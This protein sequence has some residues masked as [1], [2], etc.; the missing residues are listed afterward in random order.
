MTAA[1]FG[2]TLEQL[3][4]SDKGDHDPERAA[5]A[6]GDILGFF[7]SEA[8]S[9]SDSA[10]SRGIGDQG[11]TTNTTT[12]KTE[13]DA[14][15]VGSTG[16]HASPVP[17]GTGISG[18]YGE[19]RGGRAHGGI[20]FAVPVGTTL[21][22]AASGTITNASNADPGGYGLYVEIT[23][24][25]GFVIRYGHMDATSVQVGDRVRAGQPVGKSGGAG[26]PNSGNSTGAHLHF[27]VQ[28][29]S[30][31]IDPTPFLAG[32]YQIL[33]GVDTGTTTSVTTPDP[34]ALAAVQ[35]QNIVSGLSGG[36]L[37]PTDQTTTTTTTGAQQPSAGSTG[38]FARDLLAGIGAPITEAN[39]RAIEAWVRAEGMDAENN[40]PLAT[41]WQVDGARVLNSHGVKAYSSYAQ[42]L[43]A[44]IKT[45][46]NGL[47]G[48][49]IQALM[50]GSDPMA[51]A[52]AIESSP[53]GT[54]GLVKKIL[55]GG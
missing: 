11:I 50:S 36:A 22:A 10:I 24:D 51:V 8:M 49:I 26:G 33:G 1:D 41:T 53:W 2:S 37:Q 16:D 3:F 35:I 48:N 12:T 20:D 18:A 21:L 14:H 17:E 43:D 4:G 34:Q 32:G 7:H 55:G 13:G 44:T 40:N 47:Y 31:S 27:E 42:G 52:N 19:N 38:N 28:K 45:L 15:A 29:D 39:I 46:T 25:D 5:S 30:H 54:G 6:L 23:T 9:T